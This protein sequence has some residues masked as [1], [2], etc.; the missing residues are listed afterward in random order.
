[1]PRR[2]ADQIAAS[3]LLVGALDRGELLAEGGVVGKGVEFLERVDIVEE[4][5]A[6][7]LADERG[8]AR[9]ALDQPAPRRD[10][11]GLV[12]DA[13]GIEPVQVGEHRLL[14]Q[15]GVK[16]RDAVDRVRAD[17]GEIAHAHA[18]LAV[19]ARSARCG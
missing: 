4:A 11:V 6:D 16:G 15:L 2:S 12:V 19:F 13:V 18:A 17:K 14:H 9:I 10:A 7:R 3:L 8:Q 5:V 1:M